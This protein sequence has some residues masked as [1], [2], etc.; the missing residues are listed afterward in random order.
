MRVEISVESV[1]GVRVAARAGDVSC[2]GV[3]VPPGYDHFETDPDEVQ[4]SRRWCSTAG[5]GA[6]A[7][8]QNKE[9]LGKPGITRLALNKASCRVRVS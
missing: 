4:P 9:F 2:A 5:S 7:G 1:D 6:K 3:G 8:L